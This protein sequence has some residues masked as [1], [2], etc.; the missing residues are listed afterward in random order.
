MLRKR[1][2][3]A[4]EL[5]DA[6]VRKLRYLRRNTGNREFVKDREG[7]VDRAA[8]HLCSVTSEALE[9]A[10]VVG[11]PLTLVDHG[12]L[13]VSHY[14]VFPHIP[15]G[16]R[17]KV[18]RGDRPLELDLVRL[19]SGGLQLRCMRFQ[20]VYTG[21]MLLRFFAAQ[22]CARLA[23]LDLPEEIWMIIMEYVMANTRPL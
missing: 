2:Q 22:E 1:A 17:W 13:L 19:A 23:D 8:Q 18:D 4:T 14:Y 3:R 12:G 11:V 9:Y 10:K 7:H 6:L 16:F 20:E 5:G 15:D 21:E